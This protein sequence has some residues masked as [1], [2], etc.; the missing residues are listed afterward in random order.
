MRLRRYQRLLEHG[1]IRT[2]RSD[3]ARVGRH[4]HPWYLVR[5]RHH[6]KTF[7]KVEWPTVA[8]G[9]EYARLDMAGAALSG[10]LGIF[11]R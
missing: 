3:I 6:S 1:A 7:R 9:R 4:L 11:H 10:W 2:Y 5:D 8:V